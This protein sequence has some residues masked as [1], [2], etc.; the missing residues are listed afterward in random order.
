MLIVKI[1]LSV[2][3]KHVNNL[4][5]CELLLCCRRRR[6]IAVKQIQI[7]YITSS[8]ENFVLLFGRLERL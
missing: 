2:L 4:L 7:Q 1:I 3:T 8:Y 5:L 6:L